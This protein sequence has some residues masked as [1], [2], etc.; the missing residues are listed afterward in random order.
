MF[1]KWVT[2]MKCVYTIFGFLASGFLFGQ[3]V[4]TSCVSN[5]NADTLGKD[6]LNC[7][8]R[9][10]S[11]HGLYREGADFIQIYIDRSPEDPWLPY[12]LGHFEREYD[13]RLASQSFE[14]AA[15]GFLRDGNPFQ[16]YKSFT[17]AEIYYTR[18]EDRQ[19][20][21]RIDHEIN[22]LVE[23]ADDDLIWAYAKHRLAIQLYD[24]GR[25]LD[26]ALSLLA[27]AYE[28]A[29]P[30]GPL[31][32]KAWIT[33]DQFAIGW[34]LGLE[35][36][37]KD[38][39]AEYTQICEQ[40]N[41]PVDLALAYYRHVIVHFMETPT[42]ENQS[43]ALEQSQ[44]AYDYA[45][46]HGNFELKALS[47]NALARL[48]SGETR[49]QLF[50]EAI[51]YA[52]EGELYYL[53]S[54]TKALLGLHHADESPETGRA[55]LTDA[56]ADRQ[57]RMNFRQKTYSWEYFLLPYWALLPREEALERSLLELARIEAY[58]E[59]QVEDLTQIQLFMVWSRAFYWLSGRLLLEH[60]SFPNADYQ[61]LAF[62]LVERVRARSLLE[63]LGGEKTAQPEVELTESDMESLVEKN[64]Q[65]FLK[66]LTNNQDQLER[67]GTTPA[68]ASA[69][70]GAI[71]EKAMD[72]NLAEQSF[73]SL[74][75]VQGTL[76]SNE[77]LL[78]FQLQP[79][80]NFFG[81]FAGGSWL[82]SVTKDEVKS[83]QLP[84]YVEIL[85]KM[86]LFLGLVENANG[87]RDADSIVGIIY[88]VLLK[89][90]I[91][92]LPDHVDKLWV[93]PD[94]ILCK[95]PFGFLRS[96]EDTLTLAERFEITTI[97][98]AT[99][100][101]KWRQENPSLTNKT[102]LSLS[103]PV[104]P[105]M[106]FPTIQSSMRG[107]ESH[108]ENDLGR[109]PFA[110]I[111]GEFLVK[112]LGKSSKLLLGQE[113]SEA[114]IK[115]APLDQYGIL[116]FAA[117]A[118]AGQEHYNKSAVV[119][120]PG[121]G[122]DGW[123]SPDEI[124]KLQLNGQIVVLSACQSATG[125][126]FQ[127]EGVMSLGRAFFQAGAQ[128][129]IGSLWK[130]RDDDAAYLFEAFYR[131]LAKGLSVSQAMQAAQIERMKAGGP[132]TTW[133]GVT[134]LGNGDLVPFPGGKTKAQLMR[135][136]GLGLTASLFLLLG[137]VL[138]RQRQ[139]KLV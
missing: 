128:V 104:L 29:F 101:M 9:E 10:A 111:E 87:S 64:Y 118:L 96:S 115:N 78:A 136:L 124:L 34:V 4:F 48:H 12:Y 36:Q 55:I 13:L 28:L 90:A 72:A 41:Q 6:E 46:E 120:A 1:E 5:P 62:Q 107:E 80:E 125:A 77:A 116:H 65:E 102:A 137:L 35:D 7:L 114:Y 44:F 8:F 57:K 138:W 89:E 106:K 45:K 95:V 103:D 127:G 113:A 105:K 49:K 24:Q 85:G 68:N 63:T 3:T 50:N 59:S 84:D 20:L 37:L 110:R 119:L 30:D 70:Q 60:E 88:D 122:E 39:L 43:L 132:A 69:A 79:R 21:E 56:L 67:Q 32:L 38:K 97:P 108:S 81:D 73:A 117:H 83:F 16:A 15:T 99:L 135:K 112:H 121:E 19:A 82:V 22:A 126:Y 23:E 33:G 2:S 123:L 76:A 25:N 26:R 94:K 17:R 14:K 92:A 100:W 91:E 75:E 11:T 42:P 134:V 130:L 98:S 52:E 133:S 66:T 131:H 47:T 27:E 93:I 129:V 86:E 74:E 40:R 71:M 53:T 18:L 54:R 58:R 139:A 31:E 51:G 61:N 109:L